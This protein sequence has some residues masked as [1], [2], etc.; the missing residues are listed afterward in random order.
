[1]LKFKEKTLMMPIEATGIQDENSGYPQAFSYKMNYFLLP[2]LAEDIERDLKPAFVPLLSAAD[3][4]LL[5][6]DGVM[7][8]FLPNFSP[9]LC[10]FIEMFGMSSKLSE[11]VS[12]NCKQYS[13]ILSLRVQHHQCPFS[14]C[15]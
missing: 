6:A 2:L 15:G 11:T 1:M 7:D 13:Y 12:L 5:A 10:L 9:P 8:D 4:I 14:I 3:W